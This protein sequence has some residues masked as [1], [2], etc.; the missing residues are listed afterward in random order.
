MC[1]RDRPFYDE[2][3]HWPRV[4]FGVGELALNNPT[5]FNLEA[6][7]LAW[8]EGFLAGDSDMEVD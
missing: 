8:L 7:Q 3:G 2:L 5:A 1:I 4:L 6:D